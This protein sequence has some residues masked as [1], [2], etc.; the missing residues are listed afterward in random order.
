MAKATKQ[1][2]G[3]TA[4]GRKRATEARNAIRNGWPDGSIGG[5]LIKGDNQ[6]TP[7]LISGLLWSITIT[8]DH[9]R[10]GCE[11]HSIDDWMGFDNRRIAEMEGSYYD[12]HG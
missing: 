3:F 4:E 8:D 10:I 1:R 7:I 9:I 5:D 11:F 6:M 12:F 2:S